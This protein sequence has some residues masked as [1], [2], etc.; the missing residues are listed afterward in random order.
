MR[1]SRSKREEVISLSYPTI[2]ARCFDVHCA[3]I[4]CH[5]HGSRSSTFSEPPSLQTHH[6]PATA[7]EPIRTSHAPQHRTITSHKTHQPTYRRLTYS[8][9]FHPSIQGNALFSP[10][11]THSDFLS[12]LHHLRTTAA[13]LHP[14]NHPTSSCLRHTYPT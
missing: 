11:S 9:Y 8:H 14:P 10:I 12:S 6:L 2:Q 4:I 3:L 5:F 7:K 1:F 13:P